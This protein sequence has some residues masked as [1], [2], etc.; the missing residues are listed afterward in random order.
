MTSH[1]EAAVADSPSAEIAK[2]MYRAYA[3]K[4][5]LATERLIAEDFNFT[6]PLDIR[7]Y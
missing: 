3:D 2:R 5:R 4:D 6:T 1:H 7:L